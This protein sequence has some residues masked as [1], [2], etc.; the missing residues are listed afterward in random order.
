MGV[1][2]EPAPWLWRVFSSVA[3]IGVA[4]LPSTET[5]RPFQFISRALLNGKLNHIPLDCTSAGGSTIALAEIAL[6]LS[7][8]HILMKTDWGFQIGRLVNRSK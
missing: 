8:L 5:F 2:D 4:P 6:I 7:A 3:K 1:E